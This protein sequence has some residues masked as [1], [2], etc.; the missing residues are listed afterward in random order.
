MSEGGV[1][2]ILGAS[3]LIG[4]FHSVIRALFVSHLVFML[5]GVVSENG[6]TPFY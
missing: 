1:Q 6:L 2:S 4:P 3:G 5:Y